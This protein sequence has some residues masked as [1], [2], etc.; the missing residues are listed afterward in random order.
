M[1]YHNLF[2]DILY[3]D[4]VHRY[5]HLPTGN[6]IPSVTTYIKQFS[7]PFNEAYWLSYKS[8]Q[9]GVTED[10]LREEWRLKGV[11]GREL[12]TIIHNYL[13]ARFQRKVIP[14]VVPDYIST[15]KVNRILSVC[16]KYYQECD[17]QYEALELVVGNDKVAGTLD[18]LMEGG[19]LRDYKTGILKVGYDTMLKPFQHLVDSSLNKYAVQLNLYRKLLNEKGVDVN[20]ME[21]VFFTEETYSIHDI[22]F[23]DVPI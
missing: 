4:D 11:I 15:D 3:Y 9:L 23:L 20:K 6:T 19:I 10:E 2:K 5:I 21:I 22:P 12:G 8:R 7:K 13:E 1:N 18:K 14:P 17:L 16:E